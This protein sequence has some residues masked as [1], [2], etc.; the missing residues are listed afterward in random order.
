MG[1]RLQRTKRKYLLMLLAGL[2]IM[3]TLTRALIGTTKPELNANTHRPAIAATKIQ[4]NRRYIRE[5]VEFHRY[6]GFEKLLIYDCDSTDDPLDVLDVYIK[7]QFVEYFKFPTE[8]TS[9]AFSILDD[10][11]Q[12]SF[13]NG[14]HALRTHALNHA[15]ALRARWFTILE[16]TQFVFP[17]APNE[18]VTSM[19]NHYAPHDVLHLKAATFGT[20]GRLTPPN[21]DMADLFAQPIID[22][23]FLRALLDDSKQTQWSRPALAFIGDPNYLQVTETGELEGVSTARVRTW[24]RGTS[25]LYLNYYKYLSREEWEARPGGYNEEEDQFH[26]AEEDDAIN[27]LIKPLRQAIHQTMLQ[28]PPVH[29]DDWDPS[30]M[31]KHLIQKGN[32]EIK[33]DLC[34]T[35]LSCRRIGYLRQAISRFINY[36]DKYEKDIAY[37]MYVTDNDSGPQVVRQISNDFPFDGV[38]TLRKNIGIGAG[39]NTLFFGICRGPYILNLEDDWMAKW[40]TWPQEVPVIKQSMRVLE[41]DPKV[42]EIWLR[43]FSNQ[44][45]YHNN[46]SGWLTTPSAPPSNMTALKDLKAPIMYRQQHHYFPIGWGAFTNGASLKSRER[47]LTIGPI[48]GVNGEHAYSKR[49]GGLGWSSAHLCYDPSGRCTDEYRV[50]DVNYDGLFAHGG[51]HRSPG[52]IELGV[53]DRPGW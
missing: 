15:R 41:T 21:R 16:V 48:T 36:M 49:A 31:D 12:I 38:L 26:S 40:E 27:H 8:N 35:F 10:A 6:V 52:N 43:D 47:L 2:V 20:N 4:N 28:F 39:L 34:V 1:G 22:A 18:S 46:R 24:V 32:P 53:E 29:A 5:W 51:A 9:H 50:H 11:P 42:L 30:L 17:P 45:P 33:P 14:V 44:T 37:E 25:P 19:L 7:Q 13:D 23:F 3:I